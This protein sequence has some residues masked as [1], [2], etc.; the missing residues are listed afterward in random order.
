VLGDTIAAVAT[1]NRAAALGIVRISG[2][3]AA[4]VLAA[5]VKD[6]RAAE[7]PRRMCWGH[8]LDPLTGRHLDDVLCFFAPGPHTAA[9]EDIAEIHGHGG[10]LVMR[11]LLDAALAAGA[12]AAQPGE[13]TYRAF[14]AGRI[15]LVQA[16]A[17]MGLISARSDRAAR[18]ALRQL[19]GG[20]AARLEADYIALTRTAAVL[21]AALDFPDEDLPAA[22]V[23]SLT[24]EIEAIA[25]SLGRLADSFAS[26]ARLAGGAVVA[27][28]GPT[29]AGKSSLLNRLAG[30]EHAIVDPEPGT[31]RDVVEVE[32]VLNGIPLRVSDTAGLHSDPGHLEGLGIA[33]AIARARTADLVVVV[34]DGADPN[35][36]T[37]AID[38]LLINDRGIG[39]PAIAAINKRDLPGWR[40]DRLPAALA[41]ALRFGV[42]ALTGEGCDELARSIGEALAA[43]EDPA[44]IVLT[45]ARQHE[46]VSSALAS[47]RNAA[48]LLRRGAL[49]ELAAADLRFAREALASLAG[50]A[51]DADVLDAV[52]SSFCIG[53]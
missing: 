51:A 43:N 22:A 20:L 46:A 26:G 4:D 48:A 17:V 11:S 29:N 16:E 24:E 18:A 40:D 50:R 13:F 53:K 35:V 15:D 6:A 14:C 39:P 23:S 8:A 38:G 12:R 9:G 45:T 31:T 36:D 1:G 7:R 47:A 33:K 41:S 25:A 21:E 19:G 37:A 49:P 3:A 2:P 42:S 30:V 10:P 44:E 5:V 32:I 52:F 28:V 27:L 34:L